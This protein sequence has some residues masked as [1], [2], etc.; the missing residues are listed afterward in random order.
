MCTADS[1]F[2]FMPASDRRPDIYT[3]PQ[4]I[5]AMHT[6]C[7]CVVRQKQMSSLFIS[8]AVLSYFTPNL[9]RY[10]SYFGAQCC[11]VQIILEINSN[12]LKSVH[13][14]PKSRHLIL[15]GT[16]LSMF[17]HIF[18][19]LKSPGA[20]LRASGQLLYYF[21]N[22]NILQ[23]GSIKI[24]QNTF[25]FKNILPKLAETDCATCMATVDMA[26]IAL[27]GALHGHSY[28]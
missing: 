2:D 13:D 7:I 8:I 10:F 21:L 1:R 16:M 5:R 26:A 12:Y 24:Q 6:S 19:I 17:V 27:L 14:V 23:F 11:G 25:K 22:K 20:L 9:P 3:G 15:N 18:P 4:L 28:I